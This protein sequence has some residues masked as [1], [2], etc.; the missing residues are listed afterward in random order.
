MPR[1]PLSP[2]DLARQLG[3]YIAIGGFT[4]GL[5]YGLWAA[6][7][8]AS[9]DYRLASGVGY[10]V[11][12]LVNYGLQKKITFQDR[13]RGLA[14]GGQFLVYWILVAASLGLTVLLVWASVAGLGL[15]EW[16]SVLVTSGV[17]LGFNFAAHRGIT[18]NPSLWDPDI[19]KGRSTS[20]PLR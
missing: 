18:F 17:I 10:A 1:P 14:M 3:W 4:T 15:Q 11:G 8:W 5:Y 20:D 19:R 12:S 6:L 13:S 7:F 9:V 2:S 16:L